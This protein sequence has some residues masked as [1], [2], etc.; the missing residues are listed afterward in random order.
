MII[1]MAAIETIQTQKPW[2]GQTFVSSKETAESDKA[3]RLEGVWWCVGV[4][5]C[6]RRTSEPVAARVKVKSCVYEVPVSVLRHC[7]CMP[8]H[9]F[10]VTNQLSNTAHT[11][12]DGMTREMG[13][14]QTLSVTL[15]FTSLATV[16]AIPSARYRVPVSS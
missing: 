13:T 10:I 3:N 2:R 6:A 11:K 5:C 1:E 14:L 16:F 15:H 12:N 9:F 4:F 7:H 8:S